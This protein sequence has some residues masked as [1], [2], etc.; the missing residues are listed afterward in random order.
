MPVHE[1]SSINSLEAGQDNSLDQRIINH[2]VSVSLSET[3]IYHGY[4]LLAFGLTEIESR[5]LPRLEFPVPDEVEVLLLENTNSLGLV[6]LPDG[7]VTI[8]DFNFVLGTNPQDDLD[9]LHC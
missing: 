5:P 2:L 7:W 9:V 4:P 3:V 1:N 8:L 6:D